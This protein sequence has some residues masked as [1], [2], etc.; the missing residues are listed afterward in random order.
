MNEFTFTLL[1][2]NFFMNWGKLCLGW[3]RWELL[4]NV[5]IINITV[6]IPRGKCRLGIGSQAGFGVNE[7]MTLGASLHFVSLQFPHSERGTASIHFKRYF[8]RSA[9]CHMLFPLL[10]K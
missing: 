1:S 4:N 3:K 5:T 6:R 7:C 8:L 9:T 2:G 10:E